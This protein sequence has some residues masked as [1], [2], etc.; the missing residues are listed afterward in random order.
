MDD[1]H[2]A[3]KIVDKINSLE[4]NKIYNLREL[5]F[6]K[7]L[8]LKATTYIENKFWKDVENL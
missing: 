3:I 2:I 8:Y 7:I 5:L 6:Y 4:E 1:F